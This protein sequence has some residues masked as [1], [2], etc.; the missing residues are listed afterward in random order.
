MKLNLPFFVPVCILFLTVAVA[1]V[2]LIFD[3]ESSVP[4]PA[5]ATTFRTCDKSPK[6]ISVYNF[7]EKF[8]TNSSQIIKSLKEYRNRNREQWRSYLQDDPEILQSTQF[9]PKSLPYSGFVKTV[10]KCYNNHFNLI[11]RPDDIWTAIMSQFSYYLNKNVEK[12]RN[13]FVNFEE[14]RELVFPLSQNETLRTISYDHMVDSQVRDWV[15]PNFSTTTDNDRVTIGVI[16]MASM[17]K[18]FDYSARA[19]CGIP[20]VTLDGTVQD[21]LNILGRLEKLK[22]Y[23][24]QRWYDLLH[25][26]IRQFVEAK[27]GKV[28]EAFWKSIVNVNGGSGRYYITGWITAFCV[29]DSDGNWQLRDETYQEVDYYEEETRPRV[30]ISDIPSGIVEVDLLVEDGS[31]HESKT[32]MLAGHMAPETMDLNGI[33]L[34]PSLGWAIVLKS[35]E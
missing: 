6:N 14:K 18:Y 25:P 1:V 10:L 22:D 27:S 30:D 33:A 13:E 7:Y 3:F 34:K 11:I 8:P 24:L 29:F 15:M 28:D 2:F 26:V 9:S 32:F 17:K 12:F 5:T 21:Y 16:F 35:N 31:G 19:A 23:E 20:Y 4:P